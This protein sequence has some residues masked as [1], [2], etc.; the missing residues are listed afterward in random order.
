MVLMSFCS[1][2]GLVDGD[3]QAASQVLSLQPVTKVWFNM[4]NEGKYN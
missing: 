2:L 1:W 3:A 4:K